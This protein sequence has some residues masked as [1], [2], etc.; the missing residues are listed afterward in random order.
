MEEILQQE[1][2]KSDTSDRP[3]FT[4]FLIQIITSIGTFSKGISH[5]Q[6]DSSIYFTKTLELSVN[7]LRAL[8]NHEELRAKVNISIDGGEPILLKKNFF[9]GDFLHAPNDRLLGK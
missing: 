1:L 3:V 2:Y 5:Q 7:V 4:T 6:G 8:P 9:I